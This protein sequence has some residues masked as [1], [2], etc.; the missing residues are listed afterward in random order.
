MAA[1]RSSAQGVQ[2]GRRIL[3]HGTWFT[4]VLQLA[5]GFSLPYV[6]RACNLGATL[7]ALGLFVAAVLVGLLL[8][9]FVVLPAVYYANTRRSPAEVYRWG[10]QRH[11]FVLHEFKIGG[12]AGACRWMP[13]RWGPQVPW[14]GSW[15]SLTVAQTLITPAAALTLGQHPVPFAWALR[16]LA[17]P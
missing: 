4:P 17:V 11:G 8:W 10:A 6:C 2:P 12:A 15:S 16:R 7:A 14:K 5:A 3:A 9:G 13:W 1:I